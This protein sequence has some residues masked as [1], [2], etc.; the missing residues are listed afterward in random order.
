MLHTAEKEG[1]ED[2]FKGW[3][4][5]LVLSLRG[6]I[7]KDCKGAL[8]VLFCLVNPGVEEQRQISR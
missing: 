5:A 8:P 3:L 7:N 4:F 2:V 1:I 6:V